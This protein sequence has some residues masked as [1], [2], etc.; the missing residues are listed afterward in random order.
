MLLILFVA[1]AQKLKILFITSFTV[2]TFHLHEIP[3]SMKS[4]L[5]TDQ[6]LIKMISNVF[7]LS[8]VEPH[9]GV[10]SMIAN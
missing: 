1:A 5:L 2:L 3:F 6:L 7:K 8:F 4:Q 9:K 10:L